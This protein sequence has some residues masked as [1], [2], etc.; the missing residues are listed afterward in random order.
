MNELFG[1][2]RIIQWLLA[3]LAVE[4]LVLAVA[5][6]R[7]GRIPPPH[8][9]L[10]NLLAGGALLVALYNALARSPWPWVAVWLLIAVAAHLA[11]LWQRF[12]DWK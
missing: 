11:D 2:G 4:A 10:W 12:R 9:L 3:L 6:R 8:A 7:T 5:H 1:T